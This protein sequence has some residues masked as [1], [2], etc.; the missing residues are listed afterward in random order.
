[1]A[2][3]ANRAAK[4]NSPRIYFSNGS[5]ESPDANAFIEEIQRVQGRGF[6][7]IPFIGAGFSAA[8]GIPLIR[9]MNEY[10][11]RCIFLALGTYHDSS[12]HARE[13]W[14][15]RTDSWPPLIDP[16]HREH[17]YY[18]QAIYRELKKTKKLQIRPNPFLK[19]VTIRVNSRQTSFPRCGP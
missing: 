7:F 13:P 2:P 4:A 3:V 10:L 12:D 19:L 9:Q 15:P 11:R 16:D 14:N 8:S 1:M 6:G 18:Q 17:S 5:W